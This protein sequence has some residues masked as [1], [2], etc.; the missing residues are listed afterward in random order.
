MLLAQTIDFSSFSS[1][2]YLQSHDNN[3]SWATKT[4][5]D[6]VVSSSTPRLS[7]NTNPHPISREA[8]FPS[9]PPLLDGHPDVH[10]R[11][12]IMNAS[13]LALAHEPNAEQAFFVADL[14]QVYTQHQR[15]KSCLPEIQPFFGSLQVLLSYILGS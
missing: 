1:E 8:I 13:R 10:L 3:S 12:G 4:L 7:S 6:G 11:K 9:L 2:K 15:W 5:V 14:G